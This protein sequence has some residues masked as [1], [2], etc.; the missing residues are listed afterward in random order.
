MKFYQFF[1]LAFRN[2]DFNVH[3]DFE[4][5]DLTLRK[6][7]LLISSL[8]HVLFKK[9]FPFDLLP[10]YFIYKRIFT[11]TRIFTKSHTFIR[12]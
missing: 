2:P 11:F 10:I 6:A 7:R 3:T 12:I 9:A 8:F 4:M 5:C 1:S